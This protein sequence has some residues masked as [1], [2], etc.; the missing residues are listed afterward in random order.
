MKIIHTDKIYW[1][2]F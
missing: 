1:N 2:C